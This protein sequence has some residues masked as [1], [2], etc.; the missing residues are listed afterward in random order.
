VNLREQVYKYIR[1]LKGEPKNN[2]HIYQ[3]GS[4]HNINI[5]DGKKK[6]LW[7]EKWMCKNNTEQGKQ[8][9][10]RCQEMCEGSYTPE[11]VGISYNLKT[12]ECFLCFDHIL[13]DVEDDYGEFFEI[14]KRKR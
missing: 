12:Y 9:Q 10:L 6:T 14:P 13:T 3:H 7:M 2:E 1:K 5:S 8:T 11:C 4:T